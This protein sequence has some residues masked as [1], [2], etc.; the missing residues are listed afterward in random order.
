MDFDGYQ[1]TVQLDIRYVYYP[2]RKAR[3]DEPGHGAYIEITFAGMVAVDILWILP[4]PVIGA[5]AQSITKEHAHDRRTGPSG[6]RR[7]TLYL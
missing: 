7:R 5:L 3:V 2:A 1:G 6:S 4:A